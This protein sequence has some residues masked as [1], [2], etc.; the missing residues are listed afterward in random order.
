[1]DFRVTIGGMSFWV[2]SSVHQWAPA[3]D[4]PLS[5]FASTDPANVRVRV[6]HG[7]GDVELGRLSI[8]CDSNQWQVWE[9]PEGLAF[10]LDGNESSGAPDRLMLIDHSCSE[11][12]VYLR[13]GGSAPAYY[14]LE[15]PLD[16]ML[17]SSC[18]AVR[19]G[20]AVHAAGVVV[21]GRA[22]LFMGRSG[23]GKTTTA[24]L[25]SR[26]PDVTVLADDLVVVR[27]QGDQFI[28]YG[29]PWQGT[30]GL[31]SPASAPVER[32]YL[33][34][35]GQFN[36]QAPL[37]ADAL[38]AARL[39]SGTFLPGWSKEILGSHV[40]MIALLAEHIPCYDLAFVPD[41]SVVN[42]VRDHWT[43]N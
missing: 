37:P 38:L 39:Y 9:R 24:G 21:N 27:Q 30:R 33:I 6:H 29:T 12:D 1:M 13:S 5:L 10:T 42:Y 14:P 41:T 19:Q 36:Q 35:H 32:I 16:H 7:W 4:N 11:V 8:S 43:K 22:I 26:Q 25:W 20:M 40:E 3:S 28:A 34:R 31:C 15:Y 23:S 17:L 2:S 18:L